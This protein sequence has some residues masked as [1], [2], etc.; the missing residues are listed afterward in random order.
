MKI[1]AVDDE[2][3][4]LQVISKWL[5]R[6]GHEVLTTGDP[7]R[8]LE[9]VQTLNFDVILLDLILPGSSGI[10]LI[11]RIRQHKPRQCIVIVSA[12]E[13]TRVAVLAAQEGIE[14]YLTKPLDFGKLDEL[15]N[16]IAAA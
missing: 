10:H 8:M 6:S 16:T 14:G 3:E 11:N 15:L 5:T 9:L 13:D 1:L 2:P 4:I 7:H 12:I